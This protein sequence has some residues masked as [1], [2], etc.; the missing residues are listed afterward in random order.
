MAS[1]EDLELAKRLLGASVVS[2]EQLREALEIQ[3]DLLKK[4]RAV[5]LERVLVAKGR[6]AADAREVL[7]A[8]DPLAAQPFASYRLERAVGEGG[9]STVYAATYVPN[10]ARVA[11]KVLHA[12][13]G[14]RP[15]LVARFEEEARLLIGLEHENIVAGYEL[16]YAAGLHFFSMDLIE[17]PTVLQMIERAGAIE[18]QTAVWVTLQAAR[19]LD[20]LHANGLLHRDIKPGN[21]MIDATGRARLIDLGLVRRIETAAAPE[22]AA[23]RDEETTV[24][25]VEYIAPEQ[26]RGRG[27]ID[28]RADIYS[29]GVSLYHMVVGDVPFKGESNYE[30]MAKH[31]LSG[32]ETQKVKTRRI[33]PEVHYAI[34]KMTSKEREQRYRAMAEVIED[35]ASFLPE[36]GPPRIVLPVSNPTATASPPAPEPKKRSGEALRAIRR[37]RLD[38]R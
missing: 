24:G 30:V 13:Q 25:T 32:L 2:Q 12:V 27:D 22:A 37:R 29:L 23:A 10:K 36:G 16:G 7:S 26:A 38:S 15:D 19:A 8:P 33:P 14:L 6:I 11:V 1:R 21:V 35:L 31:I 9:S 28:V 20:Y 17:G 3:E 34:T 18:P 4:G 5:T